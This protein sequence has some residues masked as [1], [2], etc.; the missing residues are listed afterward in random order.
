M[1]SKMAYTAVL[2]LAMLVVSARVH[3]SITCAEITKLL[4][5]CISYAIVGGK[6]PPD[7]CKGLKALDAAS[8][9]TQDHRDAC[10]QLHQG[11]SFKDPRDQLPPG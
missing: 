1:A 9:T 7:C 3:A 10:M 5:P 4:T 11:R 2:L 8:T 6:V